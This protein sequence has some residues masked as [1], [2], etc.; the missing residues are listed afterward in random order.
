MPR[1]PQSRRDR[2]HGGGGPWTGGGDRARAEAASEWAPSQEAREE[3]ERL[4]RELGAAR[5]AVEE[6]A[7]AQRMGETKLRAAER[8][9][10]RVRGVVEV[11]RAELGRLLREGE[12][13]GERVGEDQGA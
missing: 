1:H 3:A 8:E 2:D 11:E 5:Q 12:R 7:V 10:Q 9:R 13:E 6:A 4:R